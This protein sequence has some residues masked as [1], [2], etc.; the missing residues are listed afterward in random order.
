MQFLVYN[1]FEQRFSASK[2]VTC[3]TELPLSDIDT[4][5]GPTDDFAS[6]FNVQVEGTLTGQTVMR[7]VAGT[8]TTR[9]HG[10][11]AIAEEFHLGE[12]DGLGRFFDVRSA[13]YVPQQRGVRTQP[14]VIALPPP[15]VQ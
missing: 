4:R 14:D 6:I 12:I 8:E 13:A 7:S 11:L 5:L 10:I 9:G 15:T 2:R 3:L 1:E